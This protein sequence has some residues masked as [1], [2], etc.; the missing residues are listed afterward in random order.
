[1]SKTKN[2]EI[3]G[4][5][6]AYARS[7]ARFCSNTCRARGGGNKKAG[8]SGRLRIPDDIRFS[9]LRRDRFSCR[10]CGITPEKRAL[11]VD[12]LKPI[13]KGGAK[14]D[15]RNLITTCQPCNSGKGT[16]ELEPHEIPPPKELP[17]GP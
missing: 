11:R 6:F 13:A 5:E 1:M 8:D 3:C 14:L 16:D 12:H 17:D 4:K 2:C 15:P 7:T 9:V 10:F